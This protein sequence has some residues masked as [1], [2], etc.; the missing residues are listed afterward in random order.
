MTSVPIVRRLTL[1]KTDEPRYAR[2]DDEIDFQCVDLMLVTGG[3]LPEAGTDP[4]SSGR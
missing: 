1:V 2:G 4:T 3:V